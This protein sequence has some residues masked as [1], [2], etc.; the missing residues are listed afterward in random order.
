MK[1][2]IISI[3][4]HQLRSG[5]VPEPNEFDDHM[6]HIRAHKELLTDAA[7]VYDEQVNEAIIAHINKHIRMMRDTR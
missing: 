4:N 6:E 1:D 2:L 3:E 7:N 5:S